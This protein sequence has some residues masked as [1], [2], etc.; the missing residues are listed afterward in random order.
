M[1][2]K[3][4]CPQGRRPLVPSLCPARPSSSSPL[5]FP[6]RPECAWWGGESGVADLFFRRRYLLLPTPQLALSLACVHMSP[7]EAFGWG[8]SDQSGHQQPRP[9]AGAVAW[10]VEDADC[11]AAPHCPAAPSGGCV[12]FPRLSFPVC[13]AGGSRTPSQGH[14]EDAVRSQRAEGSREGSPGWAGGFYS[15][16]ATHLWWGHLPVGGDGCR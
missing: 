10:A 5:Q 12:P 3:G 8:Q 16:P 7:P 14:W 15:G 6:G 11:G 4:T 9:A 13:D 2:L 1:H